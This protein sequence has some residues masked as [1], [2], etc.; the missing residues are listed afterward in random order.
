MITADPE[1]RSTGPLVATID[2]LFL[3]VAFFVLVLFFVQQQQKQSIQQLESVQQRLEA[4]SEEKSTIERVLE[5]VQPF[6]PKIDALKKAE[7]ERRRAEEARAA[8]KREKEGLRV[9]YEVLPGGGIGYQGHTYTLEQFAGDVVT[10]LRE[11]HWLAFRAQAQP[12]TSF[13]TVVQSRGRLLEAQGEFD[14]YWDNLTSTKS[15]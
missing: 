14:T 15:Q 1:R 5:Q 9:E 11:K 6:L 8:R 2:L 12:E 13:G 4:V 7:V 3:V 10:P